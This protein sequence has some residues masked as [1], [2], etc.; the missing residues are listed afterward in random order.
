MTF[1]M[2]RSLQKAEIE[3]HYRA[4]ATEILPPHLDSVPVINVVKWDGDGDGGS[5]REV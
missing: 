1:P 4:S 3:S 2:V 5:S